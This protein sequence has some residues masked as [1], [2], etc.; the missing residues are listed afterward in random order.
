MRGLGLFGRTPLLA[1]NRRRQLLLALAAL[2]VLAAVVGLVVAA[3]RGIR[4]G[5]PATGP[6]LPNRFE[7]LEAA[8]GQAR[9]SK[10]AVIAAFLSPTDKLLDSPEVRE[11]VE[12]P[13]LIL[14]EF[15]SAAPEFDAAARQFSVDR[16]KLP[17]FVFLSPDGKILMK[18]VEPTEEQHLTG[19]IR[20][21]GPLMARWIS[22]QS[23]P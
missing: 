4:P 5:V 22:E 1:L 18:I 21:V 9:R 2:A 14:V 17:T 8:L 19:A 12:G 10:R 20:N 3:T 6:E 15:R 13:G 16:E 23:K 11:A 7:N